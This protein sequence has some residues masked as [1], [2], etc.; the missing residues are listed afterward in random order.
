MPRLAD[1]GFYSRSSDK[2]VTSGRGWPARPLKNRQVTSWNIGRLA[3][4]WIGEANPIYVNRATN[5]SR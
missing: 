1:R 5:L 2:A 4:V 3:R